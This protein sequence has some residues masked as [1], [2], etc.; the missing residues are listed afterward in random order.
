LARLT[1]VPGGAW[2]LLFGV[3]ALGALAVSALWLIR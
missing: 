3:V 1:G 2:I